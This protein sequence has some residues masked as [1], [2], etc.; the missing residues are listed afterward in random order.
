MGENFI[1]S[2]STLKMAVHRTHLSC[3]SSLKS[4]SLKTRI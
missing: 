3:F 4:R 1:P 2:E